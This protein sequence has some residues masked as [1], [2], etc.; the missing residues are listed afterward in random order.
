MP[1]IYSH[2][3]RDQLQSAEL[4]SFCIAQQ[5]REIKHMIID[6][7]FEQ[8]ISLLSCFP[9]P[10][11]GFLVYVGTRD[12][13]S[14]QVHFLHF[15]EGVPIQQWHLTYQT[16]LKYVFTSHRNSNQFHAGCQ[17]ILHLLT[18]TFS[19]LKALS[20]ISRFPRLHYTSRK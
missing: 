7:S 9:L 8:N 17:A 18:N 19:I 10:S 2:A 11:H 16:T 13:L 12:P 15:L 5:Y 3:T 14:L 4:Y 6:Q 20:G 1:T